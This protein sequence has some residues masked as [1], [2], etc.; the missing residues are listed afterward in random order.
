MVILSVPTH[1]LM[2]DL[3]EDITET[4]GWLE[5]E[6]ISLICHTLIYWAAHIM[7]SQ[8]EMC[9]QDLFTDTG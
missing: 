3:Q 4:R 9:V 5:G 2:S 7:M 8:C 6:S 1:L